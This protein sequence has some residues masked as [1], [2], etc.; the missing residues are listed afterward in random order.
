MLFSPNK[1]NFILIQLLSYVDLQGQMS[2]EVTK[3]HLRSQKVKNLFDAAYFKLKK[4]LTKVLQ[5][6]K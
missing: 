4:S 5:H 6:K 1:P 2:N 3:G